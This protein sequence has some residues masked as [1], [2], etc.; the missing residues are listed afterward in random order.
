MLPTY[1]SHLL[2]IEFI[3]MRKFKEVDAREGLQFCYLAK[4]KTP[5][6]TCGMFVILSINYMKAANFSGDK[7]SE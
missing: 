6:N 3:S 7:N 2:N 4:F 5:T 1:E